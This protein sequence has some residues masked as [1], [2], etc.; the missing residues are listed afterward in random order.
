ML[1]RIYKAVSSIAFSLLIVSSS[2]FSNIYPLDAAQMG[3]DVNEENSMGIIIEESNDSMS[4]IKTN[5]TPD[6]G[7][8]QAFP[9]IPGFG[10]NSGKD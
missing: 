1:N 9:F 2:F 7:D 3:S 5:P 6:L 10:K 4:G 8:D